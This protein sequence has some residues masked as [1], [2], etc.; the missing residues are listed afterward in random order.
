MNQIPA[1]ASFTFISDSCHSGGM[2]DK[3][4]EQI[5]G[6]S[7]YGPVSSGGGPGGLMGLVSQGLQA[8]GNRGLNSDQT[9]DFDNNAYGGERRQYG[10]GGYSEVR[11]SA[12]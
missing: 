8:L 9:K 7:S 10:E 4:K 3:E 5:G 1:G 11:Q 12:E 2:I 6:G